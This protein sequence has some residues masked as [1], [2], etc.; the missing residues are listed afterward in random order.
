MLG[1]PT[2]SMG[3]QSFF[4]FKQAQGVGLRVS[5]RPA[6]AIAPRFACRVF[7]GASVF[8]LLWPPLLTNLAAMTSGPPRRA[9]VGCRLGS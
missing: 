2:V 1:P 6:I 5:D 7:G 3:L 4:S 8:V 9:L